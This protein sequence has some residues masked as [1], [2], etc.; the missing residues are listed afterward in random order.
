MEN[1]IYESA[2]KKNHAKRLIVQLFIDLDNDDAGKSAK[3][4]LTAGLVKLEIKYFCISLK[5]EVL[6]CYSPYPI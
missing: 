3:Q 6:K 5:V 1:R 4:K 2:S